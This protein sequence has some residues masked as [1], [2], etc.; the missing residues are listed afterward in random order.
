MRYKY[1]YVY[2]ILR[3]FVYG[4]LM[5]KVCKPVFDLRYNKQNWRCQRKLLCSA[6]INYYNQMLCTVKCNKQGRHL[7]EYGIRNKCN[8]S[9]CSSIFTMQPIIVKSSNDNSFAFLT[10]YIYISP[11]SNELVTPAVK[12]S[13]LLEI[14]HSSTVVWFV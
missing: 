11:C 6:Q 7:F 10:G 13:R 14:M 12:S 3:N 4:V 1:C 5:V 2:C 8:H 9:Q